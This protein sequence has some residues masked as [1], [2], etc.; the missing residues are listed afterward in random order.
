MNHN[1]QNALKKKFMILLMV[2]LFPFFACSPSEKK[3]TETPVADDNPVFSKDNLIAWCVVPF[4]AEKRGPQERAKMLK[5]LGI[6]MLAYDWRDEH[7]PTF[8]EEYEA[9]KANG[10][11]LQSFWMMSGHD[12][13]NDTRVQTVFDFIERNEVETEIWLLVEKGEDFNAL[14][15]EEKVIAMAKP[16]RYVADRAA[17]NGCKVALYNHGNWFG[18]PENQLAI[19]GYLDLDNIG[20]VFNF[21]HAA[22]YQERFSEF[23]PKI[24]P[25]LYAINLAGLKKVDTGNFYGVGEGDSE[26][27]MI[28]TILNSDY[29]GPIGIINHDT[30][31][32]AEVGLETEMAG[33]NKVLQTVKE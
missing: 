33:L 25:H 31:R 12:P 9:L 8:D 6:T 18:E 19:I 29:Q 26:Y 15:Q 5:D 13:E 28:E 4:D 14:S 30:K 32:D 22:P 2:S 3:V 16:I 7:I 10:I 1:I 27:E 20:M 21:H 23:F 11:R 17:A 24:K